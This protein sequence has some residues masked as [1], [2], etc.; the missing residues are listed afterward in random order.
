[1]A[2]QGT[3]IEA[4]NTALASV[5][6]GCGGAP[7]LIA[8]ACPLLP[9]TGAFCVVNRPGQRPHYLA[10]T[11]PAGAAKDAVQL[12]V[13][14]T[15]LLNPVYNAILDGLQPGLY[16]MADLAPDNWNP[17]PETPGI[18]VEDGEEIGYRTPG[19]P[20][21]LVELTLLVELPDGAMGEISFARPAA[22]GGFP[23]DL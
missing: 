2:F 16:R 5:I 4:A 19:W 20:A 8:A 10:D 21:G 11:Y 14:S 22:Q 6:D 18:L 15:Y 13:A 12:Y 9:F 1:M 3:D 23:D 17:V 7:D